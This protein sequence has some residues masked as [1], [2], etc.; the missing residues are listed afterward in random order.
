VRLILRLILLGPALMVGSV[1]GTGS[2]ADASDWQAVIGH[3]WR[4]QELDDQPVLESTAITIV[5]DRAGRVS[6]N[7]GTNRYMGSYTRAGSDRLA[8]SDLGATKMYLD[9]P[10]GRMQQET[11]YLDLL[12][13]VE[14][15]T[16]ED[17][18]LILWVEGERSILYRRA[19]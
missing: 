9:L 7:A 3:E 16:L 19:Q 4:V 5:F 10:P 12:Q 13:S 1:L 8:V 14:R 18:G 15:F 2:T 6:G 17:D 11:T